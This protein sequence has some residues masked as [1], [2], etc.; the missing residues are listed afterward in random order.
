MSSIEIE[1][2]TSAAE[3]PPPRRDGARSRAITQPEIYITQQ[4][5]LLGGSKHRLFTRSGH[6]P[7]SEQVDV[8]RNV[9]RNMREHIDRQPIE[10]NCWP[11]RRGDRRAGCSHD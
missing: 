2:S 4:R 11:R 5:V 10:P 6:A 9:C 1:L 8:Q 3:H 7:E